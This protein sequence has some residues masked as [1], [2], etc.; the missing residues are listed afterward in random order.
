MEKV[1]Q[2]RYYGEGNTRNYPAD[3]TRSDLI[4]NIVPFLNTNGITR[5][6]IQS[7]PGIRFSIGVG[8]QAAMGPLVLGTTGVYSLDLKADERLTFVNFTLDSVQHID[9]E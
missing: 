8:S 5:L 2:C 1:Y 9:Y 7:E 4:S 3:L 6:E